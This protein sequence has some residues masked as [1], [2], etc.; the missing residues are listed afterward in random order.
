MMIS[1]VIDEYFANMLLT[2]SG[3]LRFNFLGHCLI[4]N[5]S[6]FRLVLSCFFS[7]LHCLIL[8]HHYVSKNKV[9]ISEPI[10]ITLLPC[11]EKN[12]KNNFFTLAAVE[13]FVD[14]KSKTFLRNHF[15]FPGSP[16]QYVWI[17][18]SSSV[19]DTGK[20]ENCTV[21]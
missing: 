11:Q 16:E 14:F 21:K 6:V 15:V 3:S 1:F 20:A 5:I 18:N 12:Q 7:F 13:F 2:C 17:L 19:N 4:Q 9:C 8:E 10:F